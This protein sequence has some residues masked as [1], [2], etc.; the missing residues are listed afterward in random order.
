MYHHTIAYQVSQEKQRDMI[1]EASRERRARAA[2]QAPAAEAPRRR[3]S[4][5]TWQ[6]ARSL[7]T[8]AES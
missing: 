1:A 6:L 2:R 3:Y 5:R 8:Q 7:R 4:P